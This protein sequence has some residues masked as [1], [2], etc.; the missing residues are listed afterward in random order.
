[1]Y[2][3]DICV[4]EDAKVMSSHVEQKSEQDEQA[5]KAAKTAPPPIPNKPPVV[6][7]PPIPI[8][9]PD[10]EI[11]AAEAIKRIKRKQKGEK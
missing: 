2:F 5:V 1:M 3:L 10:D 7:P 11:S 4:I 9:N 6:V 8:S